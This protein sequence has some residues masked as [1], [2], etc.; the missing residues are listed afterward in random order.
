MIGIG[1]RFKTL[2]LGII[3]I[4]TIL[5]GC[6]DIFF[7]N[8]IDIIRENWDIQLPTPTEE[9]FHESGPVSFQGD[10]E[11]YHVFEYD[12]ED[13]INS[14]I[15]WIDAKDNSINAGVQD[16][17][18]GLEIYD[19]VEIPKEFRPNIKEKYKFYTI[20]EE[21]NSKLYLVYIPGTNRIFVAEDL[22]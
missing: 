11:R 14:S 7:T 20:S 19:D 18:E 6:E 15:Q 8:C 5:F 3:V 22:F 4:C 16:I 1:N 12:N 17:I 2:L 9:I 21:D 10:G 13:I